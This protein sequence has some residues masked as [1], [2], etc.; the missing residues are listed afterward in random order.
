MTPDFLQVLQDHTV[1]RIDASRSDVVHHPREGRPFLALPAYLVLASTGMRVP[2]RSEVQVTHR[3][4]LPFRANYMVV[5]AD[6]GRFSLLDLKIGHRSQFTRDESIALR[7]FVGFYCGKREAVRP[8]P[9][10]WPLEVCG[11]SSE[12]VARAIIP[13]GDDADLGVEFEILLIGEAAVP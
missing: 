9:I 3:C 5:A 13:D 8:D 4:Q 10:Q 6:T 12:V 2:P 11:C 7:D 1:S